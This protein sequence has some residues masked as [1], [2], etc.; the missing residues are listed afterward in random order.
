MC[1]HVGTRSADDDISIRDSRYSAEKPVPGNSIGYDWLL[2]CV[3][4][5]T[6]ISR[7]QKLGISSRPGAL[8]LD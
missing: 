8:P 5:T 4:C 6:L 3:P 2:R 1:L 7:M